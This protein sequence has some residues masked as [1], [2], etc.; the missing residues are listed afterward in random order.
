MIQAHLD[1]GDV[2]VDIHIGVVLVK[3]MELAWKIP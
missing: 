1:I 2:V 3:Y